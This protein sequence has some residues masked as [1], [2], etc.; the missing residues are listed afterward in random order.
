MDSTAQEPDAQEAR[1]ALM[2]PVLDAIAVD[3]SFGRALGPV[4]GGGIFDRFDVYDW[5]FVVV[6]H[7]RHRLPDRARLAGVFHLWGAD[8]WLRGVDGHLC[9]AACG[10]RHHSRFVI[11][12]RRIREERAG[13]RKR[14]M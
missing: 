12:G 5:L 13:N 6:R 1:M 14:L 7:R 9:C 3:S 8:H 11:F 10:N 2:G 4:A